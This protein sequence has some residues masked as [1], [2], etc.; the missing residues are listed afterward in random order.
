MSSDGERIDPRLRDSH[1]RLSL[2]MAM[3]CEGKPLT[4]QLV[5][6]VE[7]IYRDHRVEARMNGIDFPELVLLA[8]DERKILR[9][10][11]RDLESGGVDAV[12]VEL[13]AQDGASPAEAA[14][15]IRRTWPHHRRPS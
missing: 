3:H 8:L 12:A 5:H 11:R 4:R 15:A 10:Y 14:R 6:E 2:K 9:F 7:G 13:V 1:A